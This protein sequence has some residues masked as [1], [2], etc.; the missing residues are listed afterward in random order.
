MAK[1]EN[2][3]DLQS[4]HRQ[5]VRDFENIQLAVRDERQQCLDDRRFYSIAGAQWEDGLGKQFENKPRFEVN[6]IHLSVI[7]IINEYRNN[8]ISVDFTDKDGKEED[9]LAETCNGL[10]RADEE[11]SCAQEAYDNGFEEA[12]G[13][14]FGAW[15]LGTEYVDE[16]DP[17]DERQRIVFEPIYD[18]DSCVFFD[19][20]SKKQDKSDAKYA[21][22][23]T[24]MT[25]EA[26]REEYDECPTSWSHD[27]DTKEF[28]WHTANTVY[29]AEYYKV[30]F[31]RVNIHVWE[32]LSG[33][34]IRMDDDE[35]EDRYD[36]LVATGAREL[37]VKRTRARKIHKY[38]M[39]GGG[40]LEDCGYIAGKNI[41]VIPVYGKRW[42]VDNI[43]RCMGH[44]RLSKDTQRLKNM[45]TSKLGELSSL[46][47]V[48]KPILAPEQVSGFEEEWAS[49]NIEN[50]PY[51]RLNP[52]TDAEGNPMPQQLNYTR[53]PMIPPAMAALLAIVETDMKDLL[54][55]Q[56]EGE[57]MVS[58]I[59]TDTA[60]LV[61]DRLD[62]QT[63]IYM[64]NMAKAVKRTGEVWLSMAKEVLVEE[65]RVLKSIGQQKEISSVEIHRPSKNADGK[66]VYENDLT[67]AKFDVVVEVGPASSTKRAATVKALSSMIQIT[68]D[69]ETRQVLSAMALMN[70]DG[71]GVGDLRKYFRDK[72]IKMKVIQPNPEEA[73]KLK[74]EAASAKPTPQDE[75][76]RAEADKAKA[77]SVESQADTILKQAKADDTR[78]NTAATL[79]GMT[80]KS[81]ELAAQLTEGLGER[82]SA[83]DLPNSP[84]QD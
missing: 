80:Q 64:S 19:L 36:R 81:V 54:G 75:Y 16:E 67:K 13:G 55:N 62:M 83:P 82:V 84:V 72:L 4:I 28:D 35:L 33:E 76:L 40:I 37:R 48:E 23:L 29:V 6:K 43:E 53:A 3:R 12:V 49:D 21:Y 38:I 5:A 9:Q 17:E 14:G 7:R 63:Y 59:S 60:H 68:T 22:V 1:S 77:E 10:Y 56:Q 52:L 2:K 8:R 79:A 25:P 50:Y 15:R 44:V 71:E 45:Q 24:S 74:A 31:A 51:L 26:F 30:E 57:Q 39:S 66:V 65:G 70:M 20:D 47:A 32:T 73:E 42:F 27:I 11:N 46:S 58:N 18:A 61:Q 41:P 78:A 69:P 34:E